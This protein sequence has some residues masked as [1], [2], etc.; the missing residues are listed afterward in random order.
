MF[1]VILGPSFLGIV[2]DTNG[3]I[4]LGEGYGKF[5]NSAFLDSNKINGKTSRLHQ[6][7]NTI[8]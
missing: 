7:S 6:I 5:N 3:L 4:K 2:G 8:Y 1:L